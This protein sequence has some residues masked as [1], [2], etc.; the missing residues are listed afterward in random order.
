MWVLPEYLPP[1]AENERSV[2]QEKKGP[3]LKKGSESSSN[4]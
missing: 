3:G 2:Q 1:P 4:H